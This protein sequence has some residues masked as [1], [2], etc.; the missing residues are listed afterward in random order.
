MKF[1]AIAFGAL[2][3]M[4]GSVNAQELIFA[5]NDDGPHR[6]HILN[7]QT[8]A[9][10]VVPTADGAVW[11]AA[12]SPD[13]KR[14]IYTLQTDTDAQV[15]VANRDG[16]EATQLT[17]EQQYAFHPSFSPDG[18]KI[19]Y[20]RLS[21][22]QL[23]LMNADGSNAQ[24]IAES[25]AYDSFPVFFKD[26]QRLLFHSRRIESEFGDPGLF[27]VDTNTG[28]ITHTGHFGTYAYPSP[29]GQSVVYSGKRDRDADRDIFIGKIGAPGTANPLTEGGGYD[30]HP[31]F[32]PDGKQIVF[33]SR[34][35]Q[36][37]GFSRDEESD[38][39]GTNE[40]FIMNTDG[41]GVRQLTNGGAVAWHPLVRD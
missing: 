21:E 28:S 33:V 38:T 31:A 3:L 18:A 7:L 24:V 14:V 37:P 22:Q 20:S 36:D 8:G 27:V 15:F 40:V 1:Q 32:T 39:A 23:V 10:I 5:Y 6:A 11:N 35:A 4:C 34:M 13:G 30:G 16:S 25:E 19:V 41:S 12:F 17:F 26:S 29:D 9:E 2:A